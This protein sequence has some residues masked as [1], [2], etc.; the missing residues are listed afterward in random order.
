MKNLVYLFLFQN[1]I[2][3]TKDGAYKNYSNHSKKFWLGTKK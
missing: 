1:R 2:I 3:F